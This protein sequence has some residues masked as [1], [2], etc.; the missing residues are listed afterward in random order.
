MAEKTKTKPKKYYSEID[1]LK[2]IGIFLVVLGHLS[3]KNENISHLIFSFHMPL[4]FVL[5]GFVFKRKKMSNFFLSKFRRILIP[6]IFF[7]FISFLAYYMLNFRTSIYTIKDFFIGTLLG[8]SNDYYLAWN[9]VLWF[10]SSIFLVNVL[11]NVFFRKKRWIV[12]LFLWLLGFILMYNIDAVLPFH[13]K[14]TLL[15]IPFFG[16]GILLKTNYKYLEN[17]FF[18]KYLEIKSGFLLVFGI[19]LAFLNKET[20]DLRL[21]EIGQPVL[22]YPAGILITLALLGLVKEYRSYWLIW[23]GVNSLAIMGLH[24]KI[25]FLGVKLI[26]LLPLQNNSLFFNLLVAVTMLIL[27]LPLIIILNKYTPIL[28]GRK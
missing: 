8:I 15:A 4:F 20:P 16:F 26:E 21:A 11:F 2:G 17:F 5:S 19:V 22:F 7:S 25:R 28:V 27:L 10:L 3:F 6:Y 12:L 13:I 1:I 24:L 14:S 9:V 18:N 23:L